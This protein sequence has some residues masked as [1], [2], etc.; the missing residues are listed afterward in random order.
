MPAWPI[1]I[2]LPLRIQYVPPLGCKSHMFTVFLKK[3]I[4]IN[5]YTVNT[6]LKDTWVMHPNLVRL[7]LISHVHFFTHSLEI[8][9]SQ[10]DKS[11]SN[12]LYIAMY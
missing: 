3:N 10:C 4:I 1:C 9:I 11:K 7:M 5:S 8:L 2:T 6:A 12:K